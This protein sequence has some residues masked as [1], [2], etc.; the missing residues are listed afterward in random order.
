MIKS[1]LPPIHPGDYLA[2]ILKELD[3]F[4]AQFARH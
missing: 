4:Q 2:E 1:G 3:I